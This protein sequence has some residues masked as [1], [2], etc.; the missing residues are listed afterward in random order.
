MND[1]TIA[2]NGG[3]GIHIGDCLG[4]GGNF[5]IFAVGNRIN[6]NSIF[7]NDGFG[8]LAT[9]P[10]TGNPANNDQAAPIL[11][12]AVR[13][14]NEDDVRIRGDLTSHANQ[15]FRIEFFRNSACDTLDPNLGGEGED[16]L[17][18]AWLHQ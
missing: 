12:G 5:S 8:I 16:F 18:F 17:G 13:G 1:N 3:A 11:S 10:L 2:F 4:F 9:T 14:T 15:Q 7:E 6:R